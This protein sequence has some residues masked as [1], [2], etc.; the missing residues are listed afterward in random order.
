LEASCLHIPNPIPL[1][2][3][4]TTAHLENKRRKKLKRMK[5]EEK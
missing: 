2:D 3:P 4:V 1:F 5:R